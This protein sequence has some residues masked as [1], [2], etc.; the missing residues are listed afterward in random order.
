MTLGSRVAIPVLVGFSLA[1]RTLS[2]QTP[3]SESVTETSLADAVV[4]KDG[5]FL[6]G[7]IVEL[8]PASHVSLRLPSG[9]VRRIPMTEVASVERGGKPVTLGG[10]PAPTATT[11]GAATAAAP[12]VAAPAPA[13][14]STAA[15]APDQTELDRILA[16][17][18]GPRIRLEAR[19]NGPAFLQRRIGDDQEGVVAYHLVCKLPCGVDLP[20][21]DTTP[22]RIGM[23]R[24]QPTDWFALPKYDAHVKADLVSAMYPVWMRSMLV[25]GFVFGVTGG[26]FYGINELSGKKEWARD[27]GFVLMGLGGACFV[28]SGLFWLFSPQTSY[29][30]EKAH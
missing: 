15:A 1:T 7:L 2:A 3:P 13:N 8:E 26:A 23:A 4:L 10:A 20:A 24:L 27:T 9:E 22:Y 19:A 21:A 25:G 18:P 5:S 11:P 17:I 12:V 28:A 6:R 14:P 30:I 16:A 29:V